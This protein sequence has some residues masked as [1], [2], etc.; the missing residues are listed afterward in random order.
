MSNI[1]IVAPFCSLPGEPYFN[2]FLF[3][4][5]L[6]SEKHTV[7]LVTSSFRHFDKSHRKPQDNTNRYRVVLLHEPGYKSNV[8]LSRVISHRKF[9]KNLDLWLTKQKSFD[10][11]YSAF[12]LIQSNLIIKKLKA[13]LGAKHIVD[14]Q[15]V[16]PESI[17]S[18]I[19]WVSKIP[20]KL[21]PFSTKA[22]LAYSSADALVAVSQT[23]LNRALKEKPGTPAKVVYIG[24][25]FET[26]NNAKKIPLSDKLKLVYIGTL[27]HSY[28]IE[29][30]IV[31]VDEL[32]QE[33]FDVE[34][35][36]LGGGPFEK[37]LRALNCK[38]VFFHGFHEYRKAIGF[39]KSCDIA[40]NPLIKTASQSV[41]NKLS[42]YLAIGIP[43][44]NSQENP[45]VLALLQSVTHA[46]YTPG[47]TTS[48]K[49]A[50]KNIYRIRESLKFHPD[51]RFDRSI[52]YK[53][54]EQLIDSLLTDQQT[55]II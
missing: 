54:I 9:C 43:I 40:I 53:K 48:F 42:D 15:D 52:E 29:T 4:A 28:D 35:H 36:I 5:E 23:F 1:L 37:K 41:T 25:D 18:A 22:D 12:P 11:I 26:I 46:N 44:I 45:E 10:L 6:L 50:F 3:L 30:A 55:A 20:P 17:S 14:V 7:T 31:S 13:K 33:G 16:W 27:S 32:S 19:P 8:S 47:S 49:E 34:L 21:I 38:N 24:S 51:I 2:R 39:V